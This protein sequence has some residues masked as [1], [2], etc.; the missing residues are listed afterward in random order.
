VNDRIKMAID[1]VEEIEFVHI[2]RSKV[3]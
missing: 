2:D 3:I 1:K